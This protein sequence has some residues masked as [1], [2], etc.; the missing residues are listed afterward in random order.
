MSKVKRSE[1]T[2]GE[3][4]RLNIVAKAAV[5]FNQRGV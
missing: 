5:I 3:K 4:S 1:L 2:K